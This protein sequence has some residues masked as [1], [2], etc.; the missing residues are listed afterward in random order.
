MCD[1]MTNPNTTTMT[2]PVANHDLEKQDSYTCS[3]NNNDSA[4]LLIDEAV[5]AA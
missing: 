5:A 1:F 3:E 4:T 2:R